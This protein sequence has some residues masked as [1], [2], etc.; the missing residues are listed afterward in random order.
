MMFFSLIFSDWATNVASKVI[1]SVNLYALGIIV[2]GSKLGGGW[3]FCRSSRRTAR[4]FSSQSSLTDL[5]P[6]KKHCGI[7]V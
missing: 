5:F 2:V 1:A 4:D 3:T 6:S 7:S